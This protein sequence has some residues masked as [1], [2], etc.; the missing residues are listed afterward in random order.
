[1]EFPVEVKFFLGS[2]GCQSL[3]VALSEDEFRQYVRLIQS[4]I[5]F[6]KEAL[7]RF[8]TT[9]K[10]TRKAEVDSILSEAVLEAPPSEWLLLDKVRLPLYLKLSAAARTFGMIALHRYVEPTRTDSESDDLADEAIEH[11]KEYYL[12]LRK[13]LPD[14]PMCTPFCEATGLCSTC[15]LSK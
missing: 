13:R 7:R 8:V 11:L 10:P 14:E 15:D 12:K 9:K 6:E 4:L 1:M 2:P 5:Q 3:T